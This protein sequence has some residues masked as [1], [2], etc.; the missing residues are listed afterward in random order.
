[1]MMIATSAAL[2]RLAD[3]G[4]E[5]IC[6]CGEEM[7]VGRVVSDAVAEVISDCEAVDGEIGVGIEDTIAEDSGV[8]E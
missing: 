5:V 7:L 8:E 2:A 6:S 1:M 3:Q 4:L